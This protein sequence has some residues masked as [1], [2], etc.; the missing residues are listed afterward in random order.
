MAIVKR[1]SDYA[2]RG[3][4]GGYSVEGQN[5]RLPV[6]QVDKIQSYGPT[7]AERTLAAKQTLGMLADKAKQDELEK[8][9]LAIAE[10]KAKT[11]RTNSMIEAY[12]KLFKNVPKDP[13]GNPIMTDEMRELAKAIRDRILGGGEDRMGPPLSPSEAGMTP[14]QIGSFPGLTPAPTPI[15]GGNPFVTGAKGDTYV[16]SGG[17]EVKATGKTR[18]GPSGPEIEVQLGGKKGWVP[19]NSL[20]PKDLRRPPKPSGALEKLEEFYKER[21]AGPGLDELTG[22]RRR[23]G[24]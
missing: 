18:M 9:A 2:L 4:S 17:K 13:L 14:E 24:A 19:Q 6:G 15:T 16:H 10:Q 3:G 11:D 12:G 8:R 1:L 22:A 7:S 20:K 21:Q 23:F 5:P